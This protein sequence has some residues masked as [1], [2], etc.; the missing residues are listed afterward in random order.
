MPS[1]GVT[2]ASE[3]TIGLSAK[4][5]TGQ[6]V[7]TVTNRSGSALEGRVRIVATE[8]AQAEWFT[9]DQS[10]EQEYPVEGTRQYSVQINVPR[11]V[12]PDKYGFRLDAHSVE[13]PEEDYTEGPPQEFEVTAPPVVTGGG[14]PWWLWLILGGIL[15]I[16][17]VVLV[18]ILTRPDAEPP[19]VRILAEPTQGEVPL[20]VRF[21]DQSETTEPSIRLWTFGDEEESTETDPEHIYSKP[22]EY[23]VTLQVTNPQG[24]HDTS[25]VTIIAQPPSLLLVS[26]PGG[27]KPGTHHN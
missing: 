21:T 14:P 19:L 3:E 6:A 11:D 10:E 23:T 22:R 18:V 13:R 2:L 1:F 9:L 7:F 26:Q 8:P 4:N 16:V 27:I 20:T 15:V 24:L 5:R 17:I 12:K 25:T